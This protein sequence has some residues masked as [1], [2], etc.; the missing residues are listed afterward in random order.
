M[1]DTP[2]VAATLKRMTPEEQLDILNRCLVWRHP[3]ACQ[4]QDGTT[5]DIV[6]L[7]YTD[8]L[9]DIQQ[10]LV[11]NKLSPLLIQSQ[12]MKLCEAILGSL[13]KF[14][15]ELLL[16]H[17]QCIFLMRQGR[18]LVKVVNEAKSDD[19]EAVDK[20][21]EIFIDLHNVEE[22][23]RSSI[24]EKQNKQWWRRLGRY[25]VSTS[26]ASSTEMVTAW[27]CGAVTAASVIS[28]FAAACEI[29]H[30]SP[31]SRK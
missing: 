16:Q 20:R 14:Q 24:E 23:V 19:S 15:K 29:A 10:Q 7:K 1:T 22:N 27:V 8:T 17:I 13:E 21:Y 2:D 18:V 26:S 4:A 28:I 3:Y 6:N 5:Y 30:G 9:H 11:E 12:T 31:P 25:F